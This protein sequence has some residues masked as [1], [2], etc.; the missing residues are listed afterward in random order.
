MPVGNIDSRPLWS[1]GPPRMGR[2]PH[3]LV[4]PTLHPGFAQPHYPLNHL[5]PYSR[6]RRPPTAPREPDTRSGSAQ[7]A[8]GGGKTSSGWAPA[9]LRADLEAPPQSRAHPRCQPTLSSGQGLRPRP[10]RPPCFRG[11]AAWRGLPRVV[12]G[13]VLAPR[14]Q[15]DRRRPPVGVRVSG[16]RDAGVAPRSSWNGRRPFTPPE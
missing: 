12:A 5:R 6:I 9:G 11:G 16:P 3:C 10:T 15:L 7:D 8:A 2:H 13:A 14:R 4:F 1:L